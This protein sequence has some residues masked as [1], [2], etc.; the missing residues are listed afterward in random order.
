MSINWASLAKDL[1][2]WS[3][4]ASAFLGALAHKVWSKLV[5]A[6]KE[7]AAEVAKLEA[8]AAAAAKKL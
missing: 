3:S 8:D 6:E 5:G 1:L 2:T 4:A 7:L